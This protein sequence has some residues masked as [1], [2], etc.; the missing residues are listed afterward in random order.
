MDTLGAGG[1]DF[2]AILGRNRYRQP[3]TQVTDLRIARQ[4]PTEHD[5]FHLEAAAEAFNVLNHRNVSSASAESAVNTLAYRIGS[6]QSG[7]G[8]GPSNPALATW[9][10]GFG[11]PISANATNL[12]TGRQLQFTLR[13]EF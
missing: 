13:A 7:R 10:P 5:R 8:S 4:I 3:L 6:G 2:L 12:F 11:Q 1:A 9:Q